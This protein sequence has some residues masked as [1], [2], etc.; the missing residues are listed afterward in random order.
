MTITK[1]RR[2]VDCGAPQ[3]Q[4]RRAID[5]AESGLDNVRLLNVPVWVCTNGHE[6]LAVPAVTELHAMLAQ[7]IIRKPAPLRGA[8]IRFLRRQTGLQAKEFAERIGLTPVSLSRFETNARHATRRVDLLI[9]LA[10]AALIAG[11][12]GNPFPSD[13]APL[14]ERLEAWDV[15]SHTLRHVEAA[16]PEREWE[17][18]GDIR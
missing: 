15:G 16:A 8:E 9:R 17:T 13:L 10:A 12:D 4:V 11:R 7:L 5:Y 6:E 14:V 3:E 1:V 2:C 18:A